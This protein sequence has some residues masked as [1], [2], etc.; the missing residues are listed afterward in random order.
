MLSIIEIYANSQ[1]LCIQTLV[2]HYYS[3]HV[4]SQNMKHFV[5]KFNNFSTPTARL[6]CLASE[7][8]A[9]VHWV[10]EDL[11]DS[12][13]KLQI[14]RKAWG[15]L[16]GISRKVLSSIPPFYSFTEIPLISTEHKNLDL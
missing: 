4:N 6:S 15:G 2:I 3:H 11:N 14:G 12:I 1:S 7:R 9:H 5:F 8:I 10:D 13:I 16:Q